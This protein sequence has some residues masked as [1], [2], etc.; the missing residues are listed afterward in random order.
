VATGSAAAFVLPG[1]GASNS[2]GGTSPANMGDV[3]AGSVQNIAVGTLQAIGSKPVAIGR[4][5]GGL[6]A[7]TLT[8]T[9][10]A[11]NMATSGTVS[12]SGIACNCHGSEFD[13]NGGVTSGPASAP[14]AHFAVEVD[15]SG[16]V[17]VH[18]GTLVDSSTRIP[19]A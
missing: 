12:L 13:A 16:N 5:A 10:E 11:C 8:C 3:Q 19:V 18:T 4:D 17:V 15:A 6:Y 1:C 7:M 9:H 14:L 2:S